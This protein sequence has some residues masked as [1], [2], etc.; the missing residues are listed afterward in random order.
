MKR[1]DPFDYLSEKLSLK[2]TLEG[3]AKFMPLSRKRVKSVPN[4][5]FNSP[6]NVDFLPSFRPRREA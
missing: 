1:G 5:K 3:N 6:Q 4:C 2:S